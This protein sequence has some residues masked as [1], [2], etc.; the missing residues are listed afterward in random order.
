M[1]ISFIIT[2]R[3]EDSL[4]LRATIRGLQLTATRF[5]S[6]LIVVDD[7]SEIPII[8]DDTLRNVVLIRKE[9]SIGVS[10]ARRVGCAVASGDVLI[11]MDAHLSFDPSWLSYLLP[12]IDDESIY[13]CACW[14][15]AL[16]TPRFWG[17]EFLWDPERSRGFAFIPSRRCPPAPV[18]AIP[19]IL[20][21][22][23]AIS[24][25]AY[26]RL[27]GFSPLYRVWG[28][29][30]QDLSLRAHIGG[31]QVNCVRDA[32]VGHLD[33]RTQ[34]W[35]LPPENLSFNSHVLLE[36][37]LERST[38]KIIERAMPAPRPQVRRWLNEAEICDWREVVQASRQQS[39]ADVLSKI[40]PEGPLVFHPQPALRPGIS[41]YG[42]RRAVIAAEERRLKLPPVKA[43]RAWASSQWRCLG[44][45]IDVTLH[46]SLP[47]C[48][49]TNFLPVPSEPILPAAQADIRV[50]LSPS[51][52]SMYALSVNGVVVALSTVISELL[53]LMR[54]AIASEMNEVQTDVVLL[55]G[56]R[57]EIDG[58]SI[59][60]IGSPAD[61]IHTVAAALMTLG[62]SLSGRTVVAHYL[63]EQAAL[64]PM[65]RLQ[66][67]VTYFRLKR[68]STQCEIALLPLTSAG[69]LMELLEAVIPPRSGSQRLLLP[70]A[71]F[72]ERTA[73]L[74]LLCRYGNS[75]EMGTTLREL[76]ARR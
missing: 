26:E 76:V 12:A 1:K 2:S 34:N 17:A 56:F 7:G 6:E 74:A 48:D 64:A 4:V 73:P 24:A 22:C 16:T 14:D 42:E 72:S 67:N 63:H 9:T 71:E 8:L 50:D 38:R 66:S 58:Q 29:D 5:E 31:L 59:E 28:Y 45:N 49:I 69:W 37:V 60:L 39:D 62:A 51:Q 13:C 33:V 19:M 15:Y 53:D 11:V 30:E 3:D 65:A 55:H 18:S 54:L 40:L 32:K 61:G 41:D 47:G 52:D 44:V 36:T 35:A 46:A 25:K 20:G 21:A 43:A 57:L 70:L 23:Y 68:S 27:G 75:L 10:R